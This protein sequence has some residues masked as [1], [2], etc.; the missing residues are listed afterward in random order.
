MKSKLKDKDPNTITMKSSWSECTMEDF[1]QLDELMSSPD[2]LPEVKVQHAIAVLSGE[3]PEKVG[4]LSIAQFNDLASHLDFL[5]EKPKKR[6]AHGAIEVN[7]KKFKACL[8]LSMLSVSQY[9]DFSSAIGAFNKTRDLEDLCSV[10]SVFI[11]PEGH[12][13]ND[14]YDMSQV[15]QEMKSLKVEEAL[16]VMDFFGLLSQRYMKGMLA[17]FKRLMM[18]NKT[19]TPDI[20]EKLNSLDKLLK[21]SL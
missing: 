4:S 8:D 18:E 19:L 12:E 7:G 13:Y 11:I 20:E 10:F 6:I 17:Y 2:I 9:F 1:F 3:D 15:Q 5:K 21:H 14:G 16:A